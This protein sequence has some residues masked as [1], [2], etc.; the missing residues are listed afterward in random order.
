V[1]S[2]SRCSMQAINMRKCSGCSVRYCSIDCQMSD[3]HAG[4][5]KS[6][7]RS[8]LGRWLHKFF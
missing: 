5:K 8:F 4:H 1:H 6:C 2:C 3:W 7:E